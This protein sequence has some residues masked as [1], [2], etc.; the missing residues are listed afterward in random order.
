MECLL[1]VKRVPGRFLEG[2]WMVMIRMCLKDLLVVLRG[3]FLGI[4][5]WIEKY[6]KIIKNWILSVKY[7][8]P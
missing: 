1:G 8:Y 7:L 5:Q 3:Y 4:L 6:F 2:V